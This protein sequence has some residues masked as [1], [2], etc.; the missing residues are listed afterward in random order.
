MNDFL[1]VGKII[2]VHGIKGEVKVLPLT[3][4]PNR[5]YSLKK[6]YL[7][8]DHSFTPLTIINV[9]MHKKNILLTF[10]EIKDRYEAEALK[11]CFLNIHRQ[12]AIKLDENQY[13][14]KDLIGLPVYT[15]D[16]EELGYLK[17]IL[18]TGATD[19]YVIQTEEKDLLVPA[20]KEIFK[21]IDIENKM[22]KADIPEGLMEL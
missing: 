20:L 10:K 6:V 13:F 2:N 4:D 11:G 17:D 18:Q 21:S 5:Y 7:E 19:I 14:F 22:I 15:I 3:D 9:R 8:K 12:D 16:G 1:H